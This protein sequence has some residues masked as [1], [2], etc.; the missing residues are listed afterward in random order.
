MLLRYVIE[1]VI[2]FSGIIL[3]PIHHCSLIIDQPCQLNADDLPLIRPSFA[4]KLHVTLAFAP[5][6]D[7]FDP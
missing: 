7:Q 5:W 2:R 3:R 1:C 4:T 6:M